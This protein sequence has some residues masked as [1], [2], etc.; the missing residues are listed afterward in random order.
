MKN[1]QHHSCW[2]FYLSVGNPD[3]HFE[4]VFLRKKNSRCTGPGEIALLVMCLLHKHESFSSDPR[5]RIKANVI[6]SHAYHSSAGV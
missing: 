3:A 6:V 5:T 1:L 4:S 2:P